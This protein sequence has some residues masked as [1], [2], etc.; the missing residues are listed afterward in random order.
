MQSAFLEGAKHGVIAEKEEGKRKIQALILK[1]MLAIDKDR[2]LT[3]MNCWAEFL[4]LAGGREH[5]KHFAT[6]KDYL[7]YRSIDVGKWYVAISA[8]FIFRALSC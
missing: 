5:N 6:L 4:R 8:R 2:A 1:E 7:P 3:T